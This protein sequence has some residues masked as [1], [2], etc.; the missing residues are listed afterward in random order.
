MDN[1]EELVL[2]QMTL[3]SDEVYFIF[4]PKEGRFTYVNQAFE[5]VTKRKCSELLKNPKLLL[6]IIFPEDLKYVKNHLKVIQLKKTNTFLSFRI[7]RPDHT[8]RWMRVKVY[9]I[10]NGNEIQYLSGVAEDDSARI[11][12]IFNMQKVNGWKNSTLEILSHDLRGPIGTVKMLASVIAKKLPDNPEVHK[13]T[14]LIEGISRRNIELI[15]NVLKRE[16]LDTAEVEMSRERLDVV[17]EIKQAMDIYIKSQETLEKK[18]EFTYSHEKVFAEVDSMKFLQV[19]NNL[20]SNAI[21]FT[22]TEGHIKVHLEKLEKTF[23]VTVTDNGIGIPRSLQPILFKKYTKA[24]REGLEGEDTVGLGMW[25][26]R[27]F[28]DAHGGKVWFESEEKKG[29][30]FYVEFPLGVVED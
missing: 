16:T 12:S 17:W 20:V 18:L 8:E 30:K 21:K 6:R 9:P 25:I 29:S 15:K 19:I 22:P 5:E 24:G 14:E 11:A 10:L 23:L 28:T 3:Q 2:K 7:L 1:T 13:L 4:S 27:L 26:V